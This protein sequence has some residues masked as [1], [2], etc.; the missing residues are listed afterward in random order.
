MPAL[1]RTSCAW[2]AVDLLRAQ[3]DEHEVIFGAAGDDSL[4]VFRQARGE[5]LCVNHDLSLVIA[6]AAA[7]ALHGS[8]RLSLR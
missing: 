2:R 6:E 5:R 7:G 8:R 1:S 3:I 4:A